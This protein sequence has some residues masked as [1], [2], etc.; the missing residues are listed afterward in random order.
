MNEKEQ[1]QSL[2]TMVRAQ[3]KTG[4]DPKMLHQSTLAACGVLINVMMRELEDENYWYGVKMELGK[5]EN[6]AT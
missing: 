3:I 6:P 4:H 2:Y 1:A 5:I